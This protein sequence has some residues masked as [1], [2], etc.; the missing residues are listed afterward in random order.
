MTC[1]AHSRDGWLFCGGHAGTERGIITPLISPRGGNINTTCPGDSNS[2]LI[3]QLGPPLINCSKT[4][5]RM[6]VWIL[7][8]TSISS[9][10]LHEMRVISQQFSDGY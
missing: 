10:I 7:L 6:C 4:V 9:A 2:K 5:P 3:S 1:A 8:F